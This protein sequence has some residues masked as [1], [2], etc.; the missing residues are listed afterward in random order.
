MN[1]YLYVAGPKKMRTVLFYLYEMAGAVIRKLFMKL[2]MSSASSAIGTGTVL[3]IHGAM[4][5]AAPSI[6]GSDI[7]DA[8]VDE[9]KNL[10]KFDLDGGSSF[11]MIVLMILIFLVVIVVMPMYCCGCSPYKLCK[12]RKED[13]WKREVLQMLEQRNRLDV[14]PVERGQL[15]GMGPTEV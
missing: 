11:F 1:V 14:E 8:K 5:P 6:Q 13:K 15:L 7:R 9:S 10:M 12:K 2:F 3:G 4:A